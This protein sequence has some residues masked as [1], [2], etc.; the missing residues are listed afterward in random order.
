MVPSEIGLATNLSKCVVSLVYR[1]TENI[2]SSSLASTCAGHLEASYT[3][4]GGTLPSE[5]G[6][7]SVLGMCVA[8]ILVSR[9]SVLSHGCFPCRDACDRGIVFGR[10]APN[11]TWRPGFYW[12]VLYLAARTNCDICNLSTLTYYRF[13]EVIKLVQSSLTSTI[14]TQFSKL[15]SLGNC[16]PSFSRF[17]KQT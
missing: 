1:K 6:R 2:H 8:H 13:A 11:D 5:L 4:I 9:H 16:C 7:L 3:R 14:P 17:S 15:S 10:N 12:Y